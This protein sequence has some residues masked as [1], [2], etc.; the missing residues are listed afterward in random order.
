MLI[1]LHLEPESAVP[2]ISLVFREMWDTTTLSLQLLRLDAPLDGDPLRFVVS[3]ISR[4]TSEMWGTRQ[5]WSGESLGVLLH[6]CD[7]NTVWRQF[8][9]GQGLRI[10]DPGALQ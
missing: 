5:F 6:L 10:L 1:L 3:H 7:I 2:H 9:G 4:K 8:D